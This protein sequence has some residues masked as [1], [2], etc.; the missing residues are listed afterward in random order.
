MRRIACLLCAI[1]TLL[2]VSGTETARADVYDDNPATA[3]RV[4]GETYVFV[5]GP[6]A[7]IYAKHRVDGGWSNWESLGGLTTSGP[8]AVA[9]GG[10]IHVFAR[11][12]EG[13]VWQTSLQSDG[14]WRDWISLGGYT[15]SAPAVTVRRGE[16][17]LDLV[18]R[19]GDSQLY[20]QAFV[21]NVGWSGFAAI[22]GTLTSA[23]TVNS[24]SPHLL[25]IWSRAVDGTLVQKSWTGSAWTDW[26]GLE[27]GMIGAPTSI[28]RQEG[29]INV[30]VR[31]AN[32]ATY[33]RGWTATTVGRH[34]SCSTRDDRERTRR[35]G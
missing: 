24:Q 14:G 25:N 11:G 22:G 15:L 29:V 32:D 3:S 7:A 35:R 34:G 23:A 16:G 31:G 6:D 13:A 28:S 19:G 18:V 21:P 27:G 5:R 4:P 2:G 20:Q 30:Y 17:Y 26:I 9:F 12:P 1:A 8:A 33:Q 10:T